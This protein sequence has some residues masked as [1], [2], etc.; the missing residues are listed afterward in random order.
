MRFENYCK[1]SSR[2][3]TS[4]KDY[5]SGSCICLCPILIPMK[6]ISFIWGE[7]AVEATKSLILERVA[8]TLLK[9]L[10]IVQPIN[11]SICVSLNDS[12]KNLV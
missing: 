2:L 9:S 5:F 6:I 4:S 7:R 8:I 3:K 1:S 12:F 10:G 11:L